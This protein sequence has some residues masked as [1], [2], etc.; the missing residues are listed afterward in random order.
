MGADP[1]IN[2]LAK[3]VRELQHQFKSLEPRL[4]PVQVRLADHVLPTHCWNVL[5]PEFR[6]GQGLVL[7]VREDP[8][9]RTGMAAILAGMA[10]KEEKKEDYTVEQIQEIPEVQVIKKTVEVPQVVHEPV[11]QVV[12]VPKIIPQKRIQHRTV[13]QIV[14]VPVPVEQFVDLHVL[15]E[16]EEE[17]IHV[18]KVITQQKIVQRMVKQV[19]GV[20]VPMTQEE[21]V[22]MPTVMNRRHHAE[23]EQ[24]VDIHVPHE[25]EEVVHVPKIM[26]QERIIHQQVEQVVEVPV[27]MTQKEIVHVPKVINHHRHHHVEVEL[28]ADI[29][30]PH[31]EEKIVHVPKIIPQERIIL[32]TVEQVVE[33]PVPM[34]QE[35]IVHVPAVVNHH[36]HHHVEVEQVVD[37]HVPHEKEEIVHLPKIIPQERIIQQTVEQVV[38]VPVPMT[39]EIVHVPKI[40]PQERII[41]QTVEQVVEDPEDYVGAKPTFNQAYAPQS[42]EIF[43]IPRQMKET[44]EPDLSK[45]QKQEMAIHKAYKELKAAKEEVK[46]EQAQTD[47][48]TEE[49]TETDAKSAHAKQET[50]DTRTSPSAGEKFL[51]MLKEKCQMTDKEWE[52]RQKTPQEEMAA[53][54][55][56]LSDAPNLF[57]RTLEENNQEIANRSEEKAKAESDLMEKKEAKEA[58]MLTDSEERGLLRGT[59]IGRSGCDGDNDAGLGGV[60]SLLLQSSKKQVRFAEPLEEIELA[61]TITGGHEDSGNDDAGFL[62]LLTSED[63]TAIMAVSH[64]HFDI[65]AGEEDGSGDS[66]AEEERHDDEYDSDGSEYLEWLCDKF[67]QEAGGTPWE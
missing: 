31:E 57:T 8:A 53:V 28:I 27:P 51:M 45:P 64:H 20:P 49:A 25:K 9:S 11:D 23:V 33:V 15:Q 32:Q 17:V 38:E 39:Q 43:G 50:E 13:E 58:T 59:I 6:P 2:W 61:D 47:T 56:A 46:A 60:D 63:L 48:K 35:E 1:V 55:Q 66:E 22:H 52:E 4:A 36:R 26:P 42:V 62:A 30:V 40:I 7:D 24:T 19:V 34:T 10:E 21:V 18:P 5:A 16:E 29:H 65:V 44:F 14:D 37:I 12:E 67:E 41:Q 3:A 54:S